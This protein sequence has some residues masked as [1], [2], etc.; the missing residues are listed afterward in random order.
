MSRC[1]GVLLVCAG[2]TRPAPSLFTQRPL[3]PH[4]A[5]PPL[6]CSLSPC[7]PPPPGSARPAG[8]R[9]A[10]WGVPLQTGSG[11]RGPQSECGSPL[12]RRLCS[13]GVVGGRWVG[14][15][16][17][18][19]VR[20]C[21]GGGGAARRARRCPPPRAPHPPHT[22]APPPCALTRHGDDE[23]LVAQGLETREVDRGGRLFHGGVVSN[24]LERGSQRR[25]VQP[26][27]PRPL[28][29]HGHVELELR[30]AGVGGGG[31]G[32]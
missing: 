11:S 30:G 25:R 20:V 7:L 18:G 32:G 4:P 31:G 27:A 14:C 13:G 23:V 29:C 5:P 16:V 12:G 1:W 19:R 28:C 21:V 9:S 8:R 6:P 2:T 26:G 24:A 15:R 3:P 17:G 10:A 22:L